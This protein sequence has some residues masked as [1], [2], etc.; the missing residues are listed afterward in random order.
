MCVFIDAQISALN[1]TTST[2]ESQN[3]RQMNAVYIN[4]VE[5]STI[6]LGCRLDATERQK[7]TWFY[8]Q[9]NRNGQIVNKRQLADQMSITSRMQIQK[10]KSL[11][12]LDNLR[13][14]NSG[15]YSCGISF[16][17]EDGLKNERNILQ[18]VTY[19]LQ[20]QCKLV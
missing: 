13:E 6:T 2:A 10:S 17:L 9:L 19:Y 14:A 16:R 7:V 18:N 4:S 8:Y 5:N 12:R 15:Y 3:L 1:Q 11:L 20:V